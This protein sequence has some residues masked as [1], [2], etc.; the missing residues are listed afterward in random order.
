MEG[1]KWEKFGRGIMEQDENG[2]TMTHIRS[3]LKKNIYI[4]IYTI[5][6]FNLS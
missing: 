5:L 6:T 3:N 4:F 2:K 1:D